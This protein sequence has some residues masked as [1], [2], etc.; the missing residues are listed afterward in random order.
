MAGQ[1]PLVGVAIGTVGIDGREWLQRADQVARLP[2]DRIW[3]WDHLVGR[4]AMPRP[5]LEVLALASAALARNDSMRVG[6]L[7]LDV[8]KRH[9]AVVAAWAA[10]VASYAP[11]RLLLGFGAGGDAAGHAAAGISFPPAAERIALLESAVTQVRAALEEG[12]AVLHP[13]PPI[14]FVVAGNHLE[15]IRIAAQSADGW[16]APVETFAAGCAALRKSEVDAGRRRNSVRA[17]VL[18]ELRRGEP[19]GATPFGADPAKWWAAKS[20]EGADGAI[21]TVREQ[22]DIDALGPLLQHLR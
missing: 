2:I 22:S 16:V 5:A 4:G 10:T 15:S 17:I 21:V 9:H 11:G 14:E 3:I 18:Q 13:D 19:L 20:A 7:V 1:T 6:T 12:P 8:T